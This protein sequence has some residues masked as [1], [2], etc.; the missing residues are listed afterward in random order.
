MY[1][2]EVRRPTLPSID[3][4]HFS[5]AYLS[6]LGACEMEALFCLRNANT[7]CSN[8]DLKTIGDKE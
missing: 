7:L 5:C 4:Q 2:S 6:G 3:E 1:G 8:V